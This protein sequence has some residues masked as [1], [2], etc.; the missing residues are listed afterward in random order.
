MYPLKCTHLT[1][2]TVYVCRS[3]FY[4]LLCVD[5]CLPQVSVLVKEERLQEEIKHL[6]RSLEVRAQLDDAARTS[7]ELVALQEH[8]EAA[9]A[10]SEKGVLTNLRQWAALTCAHYGVEVSILRE[11][12]RVSGTH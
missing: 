8:C 1:V 2:A 5:M 3:V 11:G 4:C 9:A 12:G 10:G 7:Q 6:R